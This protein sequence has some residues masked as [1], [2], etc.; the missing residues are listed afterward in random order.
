MARVPMVTRTV[1]VTVCNVLCLDLTKKEPFEKEVK[2]SRTYKDG[3][4]LMKRIEEVVNSDTIKA[5][6]VISAETEEILYGMSEQK[7]IESAEV[8]PARK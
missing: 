1:K 7:F 4:K 6:H 8:M 3:K 2:L 5:V